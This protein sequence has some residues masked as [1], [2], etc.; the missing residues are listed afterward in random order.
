MPSIDRQVGASNQDCRYIVGTDTFELASILFGVGCQALPNPTDQGGAGLFTNMTIP[1]GSTITLAYI[2]LTARGTYT[3]VV[4]NSRIRAQAADNAAV[5]STKADFLARAWTASFIHWDGIGA[6]TADLEYSSPDIKACVQE[7]IDRPGWLSGN[8]IAI[9]WDDFEKRTTQN[10]IRVRFGKSYDNVPA[11]APKLH[12]DY[13]EPSAGK[14][15]SAGA[16][17]A[18]GII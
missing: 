16:L 8:N 6:W 7:V 12:I 1:P 14:G 3:D 11:Q 5:F 13:E 10:P 15:S 4:V 9:L 2:T 17:I 18:A